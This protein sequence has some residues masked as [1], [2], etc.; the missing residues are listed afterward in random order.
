MAIGT[1]GA[2][3]GASVLG[4]A[5]SA[6]AA[7][8][9][10]S[11]QEAIAREQLALERQIYDDTV[12]RFEPFYSDGLDYQ[13]A[14]RFELLGGE[15]PTFDAYTPEIETIAGTPGN[16]TFI[17]PGMD[18]E[19]AQ[20][21]RRQNSLNAGT[22]ATYRVAGQTFG[23]MDEAQEY[24]NSVATDG[25]EY[26]GFQATPGYQFMLEQGQAAID[27]SAAARG[28]VFSGATIKAQ[29]EYGQGLANQE[30]NNYLNRLT[31][32]A[33]QGQAAAGN[34]ATAGA[35]YT[36]GA[37]NAFA[38]IGNAQSAGYIGQANAVNTGLNNAIGAFGYM[39]N[40]S[41]QASNGI[42][43]PSSLMQQVNGL[44]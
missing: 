42:N 24:A 3:L 36:S 15:R 27:G 17:W 4:G 18:P 16:Q 1:G 2:I 33:S 38:N 20:E 29:Q 13:N 11:A 10:A 26:Q 22:P 9:A 23:T 8:D 35:N 41:L 6:N 28:N 7:S 37:S 43:I 19:R 32:Q 31:G 44:F 25:Y 40:G 21:L 39:N 34:I 12:D 30:Y 14:L 5:A